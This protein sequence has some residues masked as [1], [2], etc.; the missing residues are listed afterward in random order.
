MISALKGLFAWPD[1]KRARQALVGDGPLS[2]RFEKVRSQAEKPEARA[3]LELTRQACEQASGAHR[4]ALQRTGLES[5]V[6]SVDASGGALAGL[7]ARLLTARAG[8]SPQA[9][10]EALKNLPDVRNEVKN[11][12]AAV[13]EKKGGAVEERA[14]YVLVG[15]VRVR[16]AA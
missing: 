1:Q 9:L 13:Q 11:L 14:D 15:G 7:G 16:K 4:E 10:L 8:D 3:I 6:Q 12:L 5:L 2:D